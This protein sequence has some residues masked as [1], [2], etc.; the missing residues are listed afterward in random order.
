MALDDI[1][2]M[3][4]EVRDLRQRVQMRP[5]VTARGASSGGALVGRI[6]GGNLLDPSASIAGIKYV[7]VAPTIATAIDP[8]ASPSLANGVGY[9]FLYRNGAQQF[10]D[11]GA[12]LVPQRVVIVNFNNV[13]R[14][15]IMFD[16]IVLLGAATTIA[17]A[18]AN[19]GYLI[20]GF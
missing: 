20:A 6:I 4:K 9:A 13:I 11:L 8:Y 16:E 5:L 19:S 18:G 3:R 14:F 17:G 15:A 7:S 12:G 2:E 10:V 1:R